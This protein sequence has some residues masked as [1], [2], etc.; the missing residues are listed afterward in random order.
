VVLLYAVPAAQP[1]R[2]CATSCHSRDFAVLTTT[3]SLTITNDTSYSKTEVD[4]KE[5]NTSNTISTQINDL[6][7]IDLQPYQLISNS[8]T[9]EEHDLHNTNT[10]NYN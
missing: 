1:A 5:T 10:S 9:K 4:T 7:V 2:V 3:N 6:P 8:Y